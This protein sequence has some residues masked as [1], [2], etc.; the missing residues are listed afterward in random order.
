MAVILGFNFFHADS[1]ACLVVDGE[2]K[3]ALAE[4]R[5]GERVKHSSAFPEN[6]IKFVLDS[7][8]LTIEDVTHI[9]IPRDTNSNRLSKMSYVVSNPVGGIGAVFEHYRRSF[10]TLSLIERLGEIFGIDHQ[11]IKAEI[12]HVEHHLAHIA[13]S[14]F[15]SPF[16]GLTAGFSYDGSG[17]FVSM[18]VARCEGGQID[19]IDKVK[20]PD[21]LGIFYT[22]LSQF[23]GFDHFGE[24]YKVMGLAAYGEDKYSSEMDVLLQYDENSW[25][26]LNT[27]YFQMHSGGGVSGEVDE[28][29]N[30]IVDLLY[31]EKLVKLLGAARSRTAEITQR[32]KD[33][34]KSIQVKFENISLQIVNKI[35]EMIDTKNIVLAGGCALNGIMNAKIL[36]ETNYENSFIHSAA[37]NDGTCVGAAYYVWNHVLKNESRFVM[38]HAFLG[39]ECPSHEVKEIAQSS[40]FFVKT[41]DDDDALIE[42]AAELISQGNVVGWYQGRSE[43]GPRALG[44]RSILANPAIINM[45]DII[46]SKIKRRESFRPFA[47][48]VLAEDVKVHFEQDVYT[49]FMMHVVKIKEKYR[50]LLPAIT[51]ED[52]TGRVQSVD[53]D[54][55]PLYYNLINALKARTGFGIVLNTSFNENEPIVD[56]PEQALSCF[57]RTGMDVLFLGRSLLMKDRNLSDL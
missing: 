22:A 29:N 13:S 9:A 52:G 47:P 44:N 51:H 20:L 55:N 25:F 21:S 38:E 11:N 45:K 35:S 8:G 1:A 15:T 57:D 37:S 14:Y 50:G 18:M 56:R 27:K 5:V 31:K 23:I 4:E 40:D 7:N 16:Q 34:A 36:A 17:D 2:L 46:N 12:I 19:I 39:P 42:S 41:F 28:K 3:A 26:K 24:E 32:D 54:S 10:K 53:A 48:S 33:I 6:A 43:W 49:P 30:P